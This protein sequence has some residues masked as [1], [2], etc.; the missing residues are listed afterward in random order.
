LADLKVKLPSTTEAAALDGV[1]ACYRIERPIYS[2]K[3]EFS[4]LNGN[5]MVP[6]VGRYLNAL[7]RMIR[8]LNIMEG[9]E[10]WVLPTGPSS[11]SCSEFPS[12]RLRRKP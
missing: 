3:T 7:A 11:R 5:L 8:A 12:R 1:P 10:P 9:D 4:F 6:E 2:H